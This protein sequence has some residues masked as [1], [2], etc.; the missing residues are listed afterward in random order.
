MLVYHSQALF[1]HPYT[2][3]YSLR[4]QA[5]MQKLSSVNCVR[6]LRR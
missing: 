3:T 2:P 5:Q 6:F 1:P 4:S